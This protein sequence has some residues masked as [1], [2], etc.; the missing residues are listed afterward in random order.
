MARDGAGQ[1]RRNDVEVAREEVAVRIGGRC[2][3]HIFLHQKSGHTLE[4]AATRGEYNKL[5]EWRKVKGETRT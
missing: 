5:C 1:L 4:E 3:V 2:L